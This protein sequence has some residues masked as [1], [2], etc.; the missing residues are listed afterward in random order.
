MKIY[1]FYG[2]CLNAYIIM[3]LLSYNVFC[4]EFMLYY[5]WL[6][7]YKIFY[8]MLPWVLKVHGGQ[9]YESFELM[10]FMIIMHN[11]LTLHDLKYTCIEPN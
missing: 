4:Y 9:Y 1:G 2:I 10:N 3:Y 5:E 7:V 8:D 11:S 6:M